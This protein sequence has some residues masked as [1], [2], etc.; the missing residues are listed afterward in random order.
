MRNI[1]LLEMEPVKDAAPCRVPGCGRKA[2]VHVNRYLDAA[3]EES[4]DLGCSGL[5]CQFHLSTLQ[6]DW[7]D[8]EF[9][10]AGRVSARV[11]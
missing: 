9:P 11:A 4:A 3:E 6:A 5:F 10:F 7:I 1:V 2:F 8:P